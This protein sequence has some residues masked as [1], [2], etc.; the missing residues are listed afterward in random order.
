MENMLRAC[1]HSLAIVS[2]HLGDH[3]DPYVYIYPH[4]SL[5]KLP[6]SNVFLK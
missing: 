3:A 6:I 1:M 5:H 4:I 2:P